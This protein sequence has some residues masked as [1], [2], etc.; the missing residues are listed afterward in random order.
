[1]AAPCC[2]SIF[3]RPTIELPRGHP[4][5]AFSDPQIHAVLKTI[6]D[7]AVRSFLH[8]MR[9]LVLQAVYGGRGQTPA[10]FRKALIRGES[11][12]KPTTVISDVDTD[13]D[14]NTTDGYTSG[15]L[16]SDEEIGLA[17]FGVGTKACRETSTTEFPT[18]TRRELFSPSSQHATVFSPGYSEGD[19]E[20]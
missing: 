4:T 18:E 11:P 5:V 10:R 9:A 1:M 19:Y 8:S 16:A 15:A 2:A 6:S 14:G 7:E 20:P 17:G 3:R 12:S 13:S